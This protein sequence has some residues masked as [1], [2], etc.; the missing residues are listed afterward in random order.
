MDGERCVYI[1]RSG[2]ERVLFGG[3]CVFLFVFSL[4]AFY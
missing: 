2:G 4:P 3:A 1:E